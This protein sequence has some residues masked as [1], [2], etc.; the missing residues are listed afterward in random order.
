MKN[1]APTQSRADCI[2]VNN[3]YRKK[4]FTVLPCYEIKWY[5]CIGCIGLIGILVILLLSSETVSYVNGKPSLSWK[6][7]A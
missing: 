4:I 5:L 1:I 7:A 3:Y 2:I 6:P